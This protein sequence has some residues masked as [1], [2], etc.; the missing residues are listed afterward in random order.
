MGQIP[1]IVVRFRFNLRCCIGG[2]LSEEVIDAVDGEECP[3]TMQDCDLAASL[4]LQDHLNAEK[5][6]S[7]KV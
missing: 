6:C 4:P 5:P 7:Q 3:S 2:D 1:S